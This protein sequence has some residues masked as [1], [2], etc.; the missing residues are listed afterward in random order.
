MDPLVASPDDDLERYR[1]YLSLLARL[2]VA[3]GL[4]AK[5]DLSGVVQQTLLEAHQALPRFRAE[6][7]AHLAAWLRRILTNNLAD[8]LRKLTTAK[9]NLG[10]ERSLEAALE[11]SSVR[12]EGWLAADQSSASQQAQ[13]DEQGLRLAEALAGLP[14]AQREA[15][16]LQHWHGW[17]LAEIA[18]HLNR[19][20]AAVAGL[21]KRGLASLR[22]VLR[23]PE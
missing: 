7:N 12:L 16:M 6:G 11:E 1:T 5:I 9:R 2:Q 21:I 23:Q 19:T 20:H 10:R 18:R 14:E 17:T 8:E 15:L 3:P 4:R 13:R 22:N